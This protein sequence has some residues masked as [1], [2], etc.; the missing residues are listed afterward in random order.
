MLFCSCKLYKFTKY[1]L[2]WYT[3]MQH[4]DWMQF[5]SLRITLL[6]ACLQKCMPYIKPLLIMQCL[7]SNKSMI[8]LMKISEKTWAKFQNL[9]PC[10]CQES[11]H[12]DDQTVQKCS[13][14]CIWLSILIHVASY[15]APMV[16]CRKTV[17][18]L[19]SY[20]PQ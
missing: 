15:N 10:H 2:E 8:D 11:C 3:L 18:H 16:A 20:M 14:V 17:N 4:G 19:A 1:V 5:I 6:F 12:K 13:L 9:M 7:N